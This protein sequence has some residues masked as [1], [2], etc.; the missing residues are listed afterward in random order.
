M[1]DYTPWVSTLQ[2]IGFT[3]VCVVNKSFQC[4]GASAQDHVPAAWYIKVGDQQVMINENQELQNDWSKLEAAFHFFK[5]KFNVIQKSATHVI[6]T[7]GDQIL[8]AKQFKHVWVL[9][10]GTKRGQLDKASDKSVKKFSGAPDG[11]NKAC[12]ALFDEVEE[13]EEE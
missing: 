11:Y 1:T 12:T 13:D 3:K 8:I 9:C 2:G 4:V 6:G 7:A 5:T 10:Q